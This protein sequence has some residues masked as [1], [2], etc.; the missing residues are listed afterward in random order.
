[1]ANL[2]KRKRLTYRCLCVLTNR[3]QSRSSCSTLE[4]SASTVESNTSCA[5]SPSNLAAPKT[6]LPTA[7]H[8]SHRASPSSLPPS[9]VRAKLDRA[10]ISSTTV[11]LSTSKCPSHRGDPWNAEDESRR[12]TTARVRKLHQVYL[13]AGHPTHLYPRSQIDIFVQVH[14]QDGGVLPAAINA[15]TLALLDAGIAMN[16][17]VASVSCGIHSTSAMLDL[18]NT[19]EQDLPHVTVAVL[20]RTKQVTLASLETRLHVERFEQIFTL[21]IEA[22]AVLHNE[23]EL[24]VRDRTKTLVQ[25]MTGKTVESA[26]AVEEADG[27]GRNHDDM[28]L[29]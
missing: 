11:P 6:P 15:S 22:A 25:A 24:A 21:A 29:V 2:V 8:R 26:T 3:Q 17:F 28:M 7:Q 5:P 23:M 9:S 1:M 27:D 4:A 20:P 12:S 19:E 18:S 10:P 16:D 14:Q 13:R